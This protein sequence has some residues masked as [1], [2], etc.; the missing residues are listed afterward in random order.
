MGSQVSLLQVMRTAWRH[1]RI[2]QQYVSNYAD[3][4]E[5]AVPR[6]YEDMDR[7]DNEEWAVM[8]PPFMRKCWPR[9]AG[10]RG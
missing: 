3:I 7:W 6:L 8:S 9:S 5:V 1:D 4:F 2:A 10:M